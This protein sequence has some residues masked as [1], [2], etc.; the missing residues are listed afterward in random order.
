MKIFSFSQR[1]LLRQEVPDAKIRLIGLDNKS[2][3]PA[4]HLTISLVALIYRFQPIITLW[5]LSSFFLFGISSILL[6]K[7]FL[8]SSSFFCNSGI[9]PVRLLFFYIFFFY[10]VLR[11]NIDINLTDWYMYRIGAIVVLQHSSLAYSP[12]WA[13][14]SFAV[15]YL[16]K[17]NTS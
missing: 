9:L 15:L 6:P 11:K 10:I 13:Y 8:Q 3:M 7:L 14:C 5:V 4:E 1:N 12:V 2:E 16:N 17:K